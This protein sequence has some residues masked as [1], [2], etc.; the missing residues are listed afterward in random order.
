MCLP[1]DLELR[2]LDNLIAL[3]QDQAECLDIKLL[4]VILL[5]ISIS[6]LH[7]PIHDGTKMLNV[8]ENVVLEYTTILLEN[9]SIFSFIFWLFSFTLERSLDLNNNLL[10][11]TGGLVKTLILNSKV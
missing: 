11:F 6:V 8:K 3:R 7:L 2:V 4:N 9:N 1:E 5:A 10:D